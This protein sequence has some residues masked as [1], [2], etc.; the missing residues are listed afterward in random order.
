MFKQEWTDVYLW[1]NMAERIDSA[2]H[3]WS[4]DVETL[5]TYRPQGVLVFKLKEMWKMA[6][7]N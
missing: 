2:L 4:R 3:S 1:E 5:Q 6:L 7:N